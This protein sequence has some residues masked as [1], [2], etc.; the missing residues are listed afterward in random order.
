MPAQIVE[1]G[2]RRDALVEEVLDDGRTVVADGIVFTLRALT[3]RFVRA[4]DPYYG[5]RLVLL[6]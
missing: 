2:G 5:V 4:G 6:G 3:G 1:L